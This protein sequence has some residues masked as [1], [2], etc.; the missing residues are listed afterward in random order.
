MNHQIL[1]QADREN[2]VSHFPHALR[3]IRDSAD[4]QRGFDQ[5]RQ[6]HHLNLCGLKRGF[7][8]SGLG[9]FSSSFAGFRRGFCFRLGH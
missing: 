2:R 1:D 4:V 8:G 5:Y 3:R 6:R 9:R 7:Q